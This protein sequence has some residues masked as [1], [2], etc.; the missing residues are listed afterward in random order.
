MKSADFYVKV[1]LNHFY[2]LKFLAS[3]LPRFIEGEYMAIR[4]M[5]RILFPILPCFILLEACKTYRRLPKDESELKVFHGSIEST[6]PYVVYIKTDEGS[7]SG[8]FISSS[9]LLT[10]AHCV[11]DESGAKMDVTWVPRGRSE[12]PTG[13]TTLEE[14]TVGRRSIFVHDSYSRSS[15]QNDVALVRFPQNRSR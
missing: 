11:T 8:T 9:V 3:I 15:Y 7:C 2:N 5:I 4:N 1:F 12:G 14:V 10:A 13:T 6:L